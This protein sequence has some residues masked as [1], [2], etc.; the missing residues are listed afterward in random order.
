MSLSTHEATSWD[1][2]SSIEIPETTSVIALHC[3]NTGGA[4][5]I[6]GSV[7][8]SI[9]TGDRVVL[10]RTDTDWRCSGVEESGWETTDFRETEAWGQAV[11]GSNNLKDLEGIAQ[12]ARSIQ[13]TAGS[14]D[15][16]CR[17]EID[18]RTFMT[19]TFDRPNKRSY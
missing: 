4:H 19:C 3:H 2:T 11:I 14:S 13:N 16:Y 6:R 17:K 15:T 5:G 10:T 9:W 12:N 8:T 7:E 18:I 1:V